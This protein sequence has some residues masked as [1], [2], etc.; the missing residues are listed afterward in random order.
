[1]ADGWYSSSLALRDG[2]FLAAMVCVGIATGALASP[3][4][5]LAL[6]LLAIRTSLKPAKTW[7]Q[8]RGG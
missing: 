2:L 3:W 1:M 7:W 6:A 5:I 8:R 4:F